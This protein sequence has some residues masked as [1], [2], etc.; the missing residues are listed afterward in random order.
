MHAVRANLQIADGEQQRLL[1]LISAGALAELCYAL[2]LTHGYLPTHLT[3]KRMDVV[4]LFGH[5]VSGMVGFTGP[6]LL[7]FAAYLAAYLVARSLRSGLATA[8]VFGW[9][10]VHAATLLLMFPGGALDVFDYGANARTLWVYHQNPLVVPPIAHPWDPFM[11]YLAWARMPSPYGPLWSLLA[12]VPV[13][14]GHG[15]VLYTVLAFKAL[16]T[17]ALLGTGWL[18]YVALGQ[19]MPTRPA[20]VLLIVWNPLLLWEAAGNGHNDFAMA[21]FIILAV[22]LEQRTLH[23]PALVALTAA[24]L[25][26]FMAVL[27]VPA[28]VLYVLLT[29]GRVGR[30]ELA[31]GL[32]LAVGV[33]ILAYLPFWRGI[34]TFEALRAQSLQV[35]GS[36]AGI[37][38]GFLSSSMAEGDARFLSKWVLSLCFGAVYIAVMA[39]PARST[40]D[41]ATSLFDV[42][43]WFLILGAF[44]FQPWYLAWLLPL[45]AVALDQRRVVAAAAF[46]FGALMM[47]VPLAFGWQTYFAH[48]GT[49]WP[50]RLGAL[51]AFP[52]PVLAW[53][54]GLWLFRNRQSDGSLP[55]P[56]VSSRT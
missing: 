5:G 47:Y 10:V 2:L 23:L 40:R 49:L 34:H 20:A 6:F 27:L 21:F 39:R 9:A 12:I 7:A 4:T 50:Y 19:G 41:L 55:A 11:Q 45:T 18:V 30:R 52:L 29:Q 43:F 1:F 48:S 26:K 56:A 13:A 14:L 32:P 36:P 38:S 35:N 53:L 37:L 28:F 54:Y 16:A 51:T 25:F 8:V 42:V 15:D 33:G 24:V 3:G 44:W 22:L 46:S 17:M 31:L